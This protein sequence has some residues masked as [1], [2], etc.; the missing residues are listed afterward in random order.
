VVS[1]VTIETKSAEPLIKKR[2]RRLE[3]HNEGCKVG[4]H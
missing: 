1:I 3:G 4:H 2:A